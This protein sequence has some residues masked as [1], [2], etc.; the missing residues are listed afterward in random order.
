[1][2]FISALK[3]LWKRRLLLAIAVAIATAA[4]IVAVYQ[5]SLSP[6][7]LSKRSS[8]EAHGSSEILVDS[9]RSPIAGSRRHLE[10]LVTRAGVFS[11]LMAG[12]RVVDQISKTTGIPSEKIGV[13]GPEPLPGEAPGVAEAAEELPYG[14]SFVQEPN[15][16]IVSIA[17]RAPTVAEARALAVA[18]PRALQQLVRSVQE[19]QQTP[20]FERIE[21]RVLGPAQVQLV[22]EG[23]GAKIGAAIF[24]GLL[25]LELALILGIPRLVSAWRETDGEAVGLPHGPDVSEPTTAPVTRSRTLPAEP[26]PV[27]DRSRRVRQR[28]GT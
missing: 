11:R 20:A 25:A 24:F 12:G 27:N 15:L 10:G 23:P 2:T 1:M 5:I 4:A 28:Q 14:L 21:V 16:P 9:A 8:L 13:V 3:E 7:S 17:T 26:K 19:R 22:E 6:P 18:A